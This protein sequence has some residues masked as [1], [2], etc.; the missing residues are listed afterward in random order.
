MYF[1]D[2]QIEN[3]PRDNSKYIDVMDSVASLS[4]INIE[5]EEIILT[6]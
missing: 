6:I 4:P 5:D 2:Y 1:Y 3:I